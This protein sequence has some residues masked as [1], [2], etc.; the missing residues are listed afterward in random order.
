MKE[1][2]Y[3][4]IAKHEAFLK[5]SG[6]GTFDQVMTFEGDQLVDH[7]GRR[8]VLVIRPPA[9]SR[10]PV[11]FLK[12]TR[13]PRKKDGL[14]SLLHRGKV[15]SCSREE[16]ENLR[17]LREAGIGTPGLV[18]YGESCSLLWERS[19]F[20]MT[21]AAD[22]GLTLEDF[23]VQC[24][25]AGER[26]RVFQALAREIGKMHQAGLAA[27]DLFARH[28]FLNATNDPPTFCIIDVARL[29]RSRKVGIKL[30]ARDLAALNITAP[31]RHVTARERV[32]FLRDYIGRVDRGLFAE[33]RK[34]TFYLAGRKKFRN[35]FKPVS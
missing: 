12:R 29:D 27:P 8:D 31:L 18:A 4:H 3:M 10:I 7:R 5:A 9:E 11:L 19:S 15:W 22:G 32:R 20:I 34:R 2:P 16:W 30:R 17:A 35:F 14:K 6:L 28:V 13:K 24:R 33:V 26:Q 21:E 25:A 1:S 23:M